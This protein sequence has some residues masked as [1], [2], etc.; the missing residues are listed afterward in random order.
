MN[1][2]L[3]SEE[4]LQPSSNPDPLGSQDLSPQIISKLSL[5]ESKDEPVLKKTDSFTVQN[6]GNPNEAHIVLVSDQEESK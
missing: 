2:P 5:E 1:N 3:T 6:G 4:L